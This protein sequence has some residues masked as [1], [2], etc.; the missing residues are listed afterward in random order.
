MYT[1]VLVGSVNIEDGLLANREA[2]VYEALTAYSAMQTQWPVAVALH[3]LS[4]K[5]EI[6][7][8]FYALSV[9]RI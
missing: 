8:C 1:E 3:I 7:Q 9:S 6:P 2:S 5:Q 4:H